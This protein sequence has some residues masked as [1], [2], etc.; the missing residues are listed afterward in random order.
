MEFLA[1]ILTPSGRRVQGR[2]SSSAEKPEKVPPE[3]RSHRVVGIAPLH[4]R[5]SQVRELVRA[6]D[7]SGDIAET[8]IGAESNVLT[9]DQLNEVVHVIEH[10]VQHVLLSET[11][12]EG[13][14]PR[15]PRLKS[16]ALRLTRISHGRDIVA[17]ASRLPVGRAGSICCR[18]HPQALRH[19]RLSCFQCSGIRIGVSW[20]AP[21]ITRDTRQIRGESVHNDRSSHGIAKRRG[22]R[23]VKVNH[24]F[25]GGVVLPD[26]HS[27][28]AEVIVACLVAIR[29]SR[30][31]VTRS[32]LPLR[33]SGNA[34]PMEHV[35]DVGDIAALER[36]S[37]RVGRVPK[38]E[39]ITICSQSA[40]KCAV[41]QKQ[42]VPLIVDPAS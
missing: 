14:R 35:P 2:A 4:Q 17:F 41:P 15:R 6:V 8:V 21:C 38:H 18:P 32:Q 24:T 26:R 30:I 1:L 40:A 25:A 5:A 20:I 23:S 31:Q 16:T 42:M 7:R 19:S 39:P 12:L 29:I 13:R 11:L 27:S 22:A 36:V 10:P 37:I 33:A 3:D 28:G 34:E 9:A